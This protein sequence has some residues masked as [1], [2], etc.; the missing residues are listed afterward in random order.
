[1]K[2]TFKKILLG[3]LIGIGS[4][5]SV[6]I[7]TAV[8]YKLMFSQKEAKLFE[9]N[10]PNF[11]KH[12]L[13]TSQGSKFKEK[14]VDTI[15][16]NLNNKEVY[17]K[18][19]DVSLLDDKIKPSDWQSIIIINSVEA[20]KLRANVDKFIRDN[21]NNKNVVLIAVSG[22]GTWENKDYEVDTIS[23]ASKMNKSDELA[24]L[25]LTKIY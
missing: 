11:K 23:T 22:S 16:D 17:I 9:I 24:Q 12:I 2:R 21:M 8:S 6:F 14:L 5:I 15:I 25:L 4:L 20:N 7:I 3:I 18:V 19:I 1:M 13:I 10:T